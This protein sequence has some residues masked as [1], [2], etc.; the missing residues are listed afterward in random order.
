VSF[1]AS[2]VVILKLHLNFLVDSFL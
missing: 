2:D 1:T